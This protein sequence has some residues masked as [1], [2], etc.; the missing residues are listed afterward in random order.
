MAN[1]EHATLVSSKPNIQPLFKEAES[2]NRL[3]RSVAGSGIEQISQLQAKWDKMEGMMESHELMI[4]E[5]V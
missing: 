3:L 1:K 5:Q 2:K 4:R